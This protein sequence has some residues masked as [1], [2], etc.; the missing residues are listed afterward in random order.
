M[1]G[2]SRLLILMVGLMPAVLFGQSRDFRAERITLDDGSGNTITIETPS[3][4]AGNWTFRLPPAGPTG[5][6]QAL[7]SDG[8]GGYT[9]SAPSGG[10][11]VP[12]GYMILGSTSTPPSGFTLTGNVTLDGTDAWVAK[13]N[14]PVTR[15]DA[16]V[17]ETGGK[18]YVFGGDDVGTVYATTHEYDP[19]TNAWTSRASFTTA[20]EALTASAVGG[21]IYVMG[22]LS[23]GGAAV[24]AINEEYDPVANSWTTKAPMPT[25]RRDIASGVAGGK[26]YVVSGRTNAS[27]TSVFTNVNEEYDPVANSWATRAVA[28]TAVREPAMVGSGGKIYMFGGAGTDGAIANTSVYDPS[29]NVWSQA[30]P[31]PFLDATLVAEEL[32]SYIYV[33]VDGATHFRFDPVANSWDV[34]SPAT[35]AWSPFANGYQAINGKLYA[36]GTHRAVFM[37][38]PETLLYLFTKS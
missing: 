32:G 9:W 35:G 13:Q 7:T 24:L 2:I 29:T 19:V 14:M 23:A 30:A 22:G 16:A 20:R 18:I 26:I 5:A 21:K 3:G 11:S 28:P 15:N 8:S 10:G 17:A 4:M 36:V 31:I 1:K 37:Y 6:G 12:T 27:G 25:A 38:T 34:I 33:L